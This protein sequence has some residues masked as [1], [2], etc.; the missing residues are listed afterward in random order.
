[1]PI[2]SQKRPARRKCTNVQMGGQDPLAPSAP[3][4]ARM[5]SMKIKTSRWWPLV[6]MGLAYAAAGGV[7]L[8]LSND[9]RVRHFSRGLVILGPI[10]SIVAL[11]LVAADRPRP[12]SP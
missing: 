3:R 4:A 8:V 11:I 2:G 6:W 5:G 9:F 1:M 7:G 12:D 10:M